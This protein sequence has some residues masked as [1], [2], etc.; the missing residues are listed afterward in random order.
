VISESAV[1]R[2]APR[3][4]P[5]VG[6][7]T[8]YRLVGGLPALHRGLP[9]P[10]LT[11]IVTL[12]DPLIM[13]EHPDPATPPG[14]YDTLVGGLHTAPAL[15]AHEGRQ[16]GVQLSLSPL[17]A[18]ALL[19]RPAG[20]LAS[21]DVDG[22]AVLGSFAEEI[23]SRL[24]DE[25]TWAARFDVLDDLLWRRINP[26][27]MPRPEVVEAWRRLTASGGAVPVAALADDL[28]WSSRYL[29]RQFATEVGLSPKV[30]GR[31]VRFDRAR[32]RLQLDSAHGG[33]L[34]LAELAVA[35]G[36]YDQA[37]MAREFGEFAGCAP[38]EFRFI[39]ADEVLALAESDV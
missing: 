23:R 39:Q 26:E 29:G 27:V 12:D 16:S 5:Y 8:G 13:V 4:R 37:H 9:S 10:H 18:R 14:T 22:T 34:T 36:Y 38:S 32:R 15:I 24:L 11:M 2:A 20:E 19:G 3:L 25:T 21:V 6:W 17:G 33:R 1:R 30:A 35:C 7:Y 31:V 28:G